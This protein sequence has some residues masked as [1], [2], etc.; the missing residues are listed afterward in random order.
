MKEERKRKK[1]REIS[2]VKLRKVKI[3][4]KRILLSKRKV[5][6]KIKMVMVNERIFIKN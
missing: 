4:S 1:K 3:D 2:K 5:K 6:K